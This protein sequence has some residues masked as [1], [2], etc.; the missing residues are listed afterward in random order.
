[1]VFSTGNE[2]GAIQINGSTEML[3]LVNHYFKW[4]VY[5]WT[6]KVRHNTNTIEKMLQANEFVDI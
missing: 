6:V 3:L 1:M 5:K 4:E 2:T